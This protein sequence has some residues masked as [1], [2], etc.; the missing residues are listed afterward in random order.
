MEGEDRTCRLPSPKLHAPAA[1]SAVGRAEAVD[2][3]RQIHDQRLR[4]KR[5][6]LDG[7]QHAPSDLFVEHMIGQGPESTLAA[8]GCLH[9]IVKVERGHL[10]GTSH[11]KRTGECGTIANGCKPKRVESCPRTPGGLRPAPSRP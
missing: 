3:G 8:N 5:R 7:Q 6:D 11:C 10:C 9:A 4:S 1:C 2:S